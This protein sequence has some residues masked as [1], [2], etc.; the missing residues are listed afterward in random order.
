[1][2]ITDVAQEKI[3][4]LIIGSREAMPD[5]NLFLRI[6]A[7]L[8][9][10]SKVKHQTYFDYETRQGDKVYTYEGFDLRL[11]ELSLPYLV[12]STVDYLDLSGFTINSPD[13]E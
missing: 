5:Y 13:Q 12:E 1:M 3:A 9:D 8:D 10:N 6:T 11:D 2:V 4:E 7:V